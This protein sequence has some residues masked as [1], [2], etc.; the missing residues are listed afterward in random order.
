MDCWMEVVAILRK[1]FLVGVLGRRNDA[2]KG[3]DGANDAN[4]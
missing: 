4:V 1:I 3:M 2:P